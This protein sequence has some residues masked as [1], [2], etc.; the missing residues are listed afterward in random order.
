MSPAWAAL[1]MA[2]AI[3]FDKKK[4]LPCCVRLEGEYGVKG[5][6]IGVPVVLGAEGVER[7][8]EMSLTD[9]EKAALEQSVASVSKVAAEVDAAG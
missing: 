3:A 7:I 9:D 8:V 1:E 2:E 4:I 6:F 5:L